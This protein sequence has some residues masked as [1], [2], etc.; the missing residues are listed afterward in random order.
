VKPVANDADAT[1]QTLFREGKVAMMI[2]GPW[3][4]ADVE[5]APGFGGLE[6][7][8]VAPVPGGSAGQ[9]APVGG[10]NYVIY[11]GMDEAKADAAIAF[12]KFMSSAESQGYT[13]DK[14]GTLPT[15]DSA[16]DLVSNE[17]VAMWESAMGVAQPRP[18]IPEG[19][20]FFAPLDVMGTEIMVQ[21]TDPQKALDKAA[22]TF[23]SEVVPD[24]S[25]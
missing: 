3:T 2:N 25:E 20:L 6:N 14:L 11:S 10:H 8:G 21:G 18:W 19:G 4:V 7:L 24:Y 9:G 13:A 22:T 16:Y 15:R 12:V 23:K 17:K 5:K 1:V